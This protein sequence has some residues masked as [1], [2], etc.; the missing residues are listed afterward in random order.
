MDWP[1][2]VSWQRS[3][4]NGQ[5]LGFAGLCHSSCDTKPYQEDWRENQESH[6]RNFCRC[7]TESWPKKIL[8]FSKISSPDAH[9]REWAVRLFKRLRSDT[10]RNAFGARPF[11][12]YSCAK[13]FFHD[14]A[15]ASCGGRHGHPLPGQCDL[16]NFFGQ[17]IS[18][19]EECSLFHF[20]E[21]RAC[22]SRCHFQ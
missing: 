1:L 18:W 14:T 22:R 13:R 5:S 19:I 8:Q 15:P 3:F 9:H 20:F 4:Q 11:A 6:V 2:N 10:I 21:I 7:L 12:K 16:G 17:A